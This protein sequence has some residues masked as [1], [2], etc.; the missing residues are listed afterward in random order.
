MQLLLKLRLFYLGHSLTFKFWI[1]PYMY[2]MKVIPETCSA[3]WIRYLLFYFHFVSEYK[4]SSECGFINLSYVQCYW[5]E[6]NDVLEL[7]Q[8][9]HRYDYSF[10]IFK[11]FFTP[12][13]PPPPGF[14]WGPCC[15]CLVLSCLVCF[16]VFVIALCLVYPKFPISLDCPY[17]LPHWFSLTFMKTA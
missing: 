7:I 12:S 13:T 4:I 5:R 17:W 15:S 8:C 6:N 14:Q 11:L 9:M 10:S 1:W 3:Q 2:L 16:V